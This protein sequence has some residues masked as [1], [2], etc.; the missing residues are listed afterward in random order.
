MFIKTS[1]NPKLNSNLKRERSSN[2]ITDKMSLIISIFYVFYLED[3]LKY[4]ML[5]QKTRDTLSGTKL[6]KEQK[7]KKQS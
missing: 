1:I 6:K 2:E 7:G 5:S 4:V 3:A